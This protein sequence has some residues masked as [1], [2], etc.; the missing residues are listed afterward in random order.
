MHNIFTLLSALVHTIL[1]SHFFEG[2]IHFIG[3]RILHGS[4]RAVRLFADEGFEKY[5][6]KYLIILFSA[7]LVLN[8]LFV[9]YRRWKGAKGWR[10][11]HTLLSIILMIFAFVL[12]IGLATFELAGGVMKI[13]VRSNS[14]IY[15]AKNQ[16]QIADS[17]LR[18]KRILCLGASITEGVYSRECSW[19]DY[20]ASI[21]G[22]VC[23]KD[24][25]PGTTITTYD[26]E[27]F[28]PRLQKYGKDSA[29]DLVIIQLST[30]DIDPSTRGT[31]S[32]GFAGPFDVSTFCGSAESM[33]LYCRDVLEC[34]VV[35][36]SVASAMVR[37]PFND[38]NA[39]YQNDQAMESICEKWNVPYLDLYCDSEFNSVDADL[40]DEWMA[41]RLHP[42]RRG[43]LEWWT[44][45][46]RENLSKLYN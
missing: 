13:N 39:L 26:E 28:L 5:G 25:Y 8:V 6:A 15:A 24:V 40:L 32:E 7:L 31:V 17:P 43:Y 4:D 30:N 35:F 42:T 37:D 18:G 9:V 44:P 3:G 19:V 29:L 11:L 22:A 34:P 2:L 14:N 41:D 23:I 16:P 20:L 38:K 36:Y 1:Y 45:Y 33:I 27:S 12:S 10:F 46:F 21:D